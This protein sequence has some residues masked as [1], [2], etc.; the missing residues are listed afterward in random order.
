[1]LMLVDESG[2]RLTTDQVIITQPVARILNVR[3]GDTASIVRKLDGRRFSIN[4]DAV[5]DTWAGKL[6]YMPLAD[7][8]EKFGLPAGSYTGTFSHVLLDLPEDESYSVVSVEEKVAGAREMMGTVEPLIGFLAGVAFIIGIVVIYVVTT[9][10]V[11]E[12]T[13]T[14]SLMKVFGHTADHGSSWGTHQVN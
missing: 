2:T 10:L 9:M 11:E 13:T 8:N 5:A 7:F 14:I 3:P 6:V 1:M 12:N 4:V